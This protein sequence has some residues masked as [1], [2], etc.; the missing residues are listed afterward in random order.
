M[1]LF[2]VDVSMTMLVLWFLVAGLLTHSG[3]RLL[4][5]NFE[6]SLD[7]GLTGLVNIVVAVVMMLYLLVKFW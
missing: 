4:K 7:N 1:H 6:D 5:T 3:I 2:S